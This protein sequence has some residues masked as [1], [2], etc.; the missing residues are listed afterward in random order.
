MRPLRFHQGDHIREEFGLPYGELVTLALLVAV[1]RARL[2]GEG[3]GWVSAPDANQRV[4]EETGLVS[5]RPVALLHRGY[6]ERHPDRKMPTYWR[7]TRRGFRLLAGVGKS[8]VEVAGVMKA[9]PF[10]VET[11]PEAPSNA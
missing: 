6:A 9:Q 3:D 4:F 7:A 5:A 1:E 2:A 8:D 11:G 10:A